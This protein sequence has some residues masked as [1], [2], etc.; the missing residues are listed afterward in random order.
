MMLVAFLIFVFHAA[1]LMIIV[2]ESYL[3]NGRKP[4]LH[5]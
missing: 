5:K 3:K 2:L 4:A 1:S